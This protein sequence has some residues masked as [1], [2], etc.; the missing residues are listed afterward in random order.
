MEMI[1]FTAAEDYPALAEKLGDE[2]LAELMTLTERIVESKL[3]KLTKDMEHV[4]G[5]LDSNP[6]R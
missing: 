2:A 4:R 5:Q 1:R 6:Y 3:S